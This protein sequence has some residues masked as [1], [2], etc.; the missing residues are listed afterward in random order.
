[1]EYKSFRL[2]LVFIC[3]LS[4]SF[5]TLA[6]KPTPSL[7]ATNLMQQNKDLVFEENKGQLMDENRKVIKNVKYYGHS[8]GVYLYCKPGMI[9]FVFTKIEKDPKEISE[10]TGLSVSG[11]E[12][13]NFEALRRKQPQPSKIF[14]DRMDLVLIN[15]NPSATIT[16]SDQ[17]EYYENYYTAGDADH[18]ITNVHTYK[19][20][21]YK[22]IYPNIDMVLQTKEQG[23]EYSFIIH[24]GGKVS[25]IQLQWNG[26]EGAKALANG[27]FKF[28]NSIGTLEE[29][30]P[31]SFSEG[32]GVES[33]FTRNGFDYR[34][35]MGRYD[36]GKDLVIDPSLVWATYYG[37]SGYDIGNGVCTDALGNSI[38]QAVQAVVAALLPLEHIKLPPEVVVFWQNSAV[39][40]AFLGLHIITEPD[41]ELVQ[42]ALGT[43]I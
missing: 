7:Q 14:T 15:S 18:G 36:E 12:V 41:K 24:S 17:Q 25:D 39:L 26:T 5:K 10:A 9:S 32:K 8:N 21:A 34:F 38:L 23:M 19:T 16:A 4:I 3:L 33:S 29:G 42:I 37:G 2:L 13:Q 1:M 31:K 35:K 11:V 40:V 20:I 6:A 43:S 27:G 30:A 28:T 22:S